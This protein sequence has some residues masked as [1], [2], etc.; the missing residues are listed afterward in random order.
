M[1]TEAVCLGNWGAILLQGRLWG[2]RP[3]AVQDQSPHTCM[4]WSRFTIASF[5]SYIASS[6]DHLK[7]CLSRGH[8]HMAP[9]KGTK[10]TI[11]NSHH[12]KHK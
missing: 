1:I 10:Y 11:S 7:P 5:P 6:T 3:V 4:P 12:N 8:V 9:A 2:A